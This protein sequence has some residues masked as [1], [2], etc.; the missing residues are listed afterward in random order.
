MTKHTV[1]IGRSEHLDITGVALAVPAKIDTGAFRSSIHAQNIKIK[2]RDGQKVLTYELFGH[3]CAP[4]PRP[5]ETTEFKMVSVTNSFGHEETRYEVM[6]KVKLST[7]I[8][9]TSFTLADRSNNLF[10]VLVGRKLLKNRFM[11]DVSRTSLNRIKLK[12]DFGVAAP[13]DEEDLED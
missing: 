6:L 9:T 3:P 11:V 8:F 13:V 1:I 2:T 7:K 12:K 10:P 5:M 4:V